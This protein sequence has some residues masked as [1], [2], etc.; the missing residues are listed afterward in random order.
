MPDGSNL[1]KKKKRKSKLPTK[2]IAPKKLS[3]RQVGY[4]TANRPKSKLQLQTKSRKPTIDI[5]NFGT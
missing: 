5:P 1:S 3:A 4:L 2:K